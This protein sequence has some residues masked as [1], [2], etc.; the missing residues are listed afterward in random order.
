M[1]HT[2]EFKIPA[3]LWITSNTIK[4]MH[5]QKQGRINSQLRQ[6]AHW[7]GKS[8]LLTSKIPTFKDK[9]DEVEFIIS[10]PTNNRFDPHNAIVVKP[11]LDGIVDSGILIDDSS[12]FIRK[13]SFVRGKTSQKGFYKVIVNIIDKGATNE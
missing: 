13:T 5:Y 2:I 11:L 1:I 4:S 7:L 12:E 9:I 8:L 3:N 6:M 10:T